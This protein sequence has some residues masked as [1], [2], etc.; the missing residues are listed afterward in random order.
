MLKKLT[1]DAYQRIANADL[2]L[3][4]NAVHLFCGNNEAGKSSLMEA[5][6]FA[7]RG[8]SPRVAYKKDLSSLVFSG[9]KNGSVS[10]VMDGFDIKRTIKDAKLSTAAPLD[11]PDML[12]DIQLG[13]ELFGRAD[14]DALRKMIGKVFQV[15]ANMDFVSQRLRAKGVSQPMIDRV[16]PLLR[17]GGFGSAF[18]AAKTKATECRARWTHV[19]SETYGATKAETWE[20]AE[21]ELYHEATAEET[22]AATKRLNDAKQAYDQ[23][24][25]K[26]GAL[27]SAAAAAD[28]FG[29]LPPLENLET[30]AQSLRDVVATT[31]DEIAASR[32]QLEHEIGAIDRMVVN[33]SQRIQA[34]KMQAA[35]LECPG[36]GK[37]LKLNTDAAQHVSLV[38]AD[39]VERRSELP[40]GI[41]LQELS[42]AEAHKAAH[43]KLS[44]EA[45]GKQER[46]VIDAQRELT[47]LEAQIA[48]HKASTGESVSADEIGV[49]QSVCEETAAELE[50]ARSA[51]AK[52]EH[53]TASHMA[54]KSR[55]VTAKSI[56]DDAAQWSRIQAA[57]GDDPESIPSELIQKTTGPLN[58]ALMEISQAWGQLPFVID[59]SMVLS[60]G[61]GM[62]Y[63]LLSESA[64]W[65]A[66]VC[67]RLALASLGPLKLVGI[68]RFD[69]LQPSARGDFIVMVERYSENNPDVT[70]LISGT[71]KEKPELGDAIKSWWISDGE[72]TA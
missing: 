61:D 43:T 57:M 18:E 22:A 35:T 50:L 25:K 5:V 1:I 55:S 4:Q 51:A 69:V 39:G 42:E 52:L 36:C 30:G 8:V 40:L 65:R 27:E 16:V 56:H 7:L 10:L 58:A 28:R 17:A 63:Y 37:P 38:S 67:I 32:R 31:Q 34:S 3:D 71:L 33:L 59:R 72:V 15:E 13:R 47:T 62:P 20:P 64:Q 21:I 24:Q 60:R 6:A 19:T 48:A 49:A 46:I 23:A 53:D 11:Y 12:V 2:D 44:S 70:V 45:I 68:D 14:G 26:M 29:R 9:K 41:L 54:A 66:E